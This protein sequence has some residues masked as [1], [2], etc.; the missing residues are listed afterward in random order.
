MKTNDKRQGFVHGPHLLDA[1]AANRL[2][3][4]SNVNCRRLL[5]KYPGQFGLNCHRRPE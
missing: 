4:P 2:T 3:R 5:E 1:P